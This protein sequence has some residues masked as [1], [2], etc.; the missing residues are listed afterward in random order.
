[1]IEQ[2]KMTYLNYYHILLVDQNIEFISNIITHWSS[3]DFGWNLSIK[4]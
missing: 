2:N 3:K 1:M 4:M